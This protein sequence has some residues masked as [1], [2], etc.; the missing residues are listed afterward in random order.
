MTAMRLHLGLLLSLMLCSGFCAPAVCQNSRIT[1]PSKYKKWLD[2][3]VRWIMTAQE[4]RDFLKL[5]SDDAREKFILAF[6]NTRNP[7][8]GNKDNSF[9]R[10]HYRRIAYANEHFVAGMPG[11]MTDRGRIYV[12]YGPPDSIKKVNV[13][14]PTDFP[15]EDWLYH[16]IEAVGDEI[17]LKFVDDC[18]CG[19]Y[20]LKN[21]PQEMYPPEL[22]LRH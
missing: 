16:H 15:E 4:R 11:W 3:D 1:L 18:L 9:K 6:W 7:A 10:E 17:S 13:A 12:V 19:A 21:E 14:K 2:E 5:S 20:E 22:R 8:P